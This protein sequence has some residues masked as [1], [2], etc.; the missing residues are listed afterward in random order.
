MSSLAEPQ[1]RPK[2]PI[3]KF[4]S[5]VPARFPTCKYGALCVKVL[6]NRGDLHVWVL[7]R[8]LKS[9]C[10]KGSISVTGK[11]IDKSAQ[12][13]GKTTIK[14][15]RVAGS[16]PRKRGALKKVN[17]DSELLAKLI[18]LG[19]VKRSA[20]AYKSV[21]ASSSWT[22]RTP[23]TVEF[24]DSVT[25]Q[26]AKE[27]LSALKTQIKQRGGASLITGFGLPEPRK[28]FQFSKR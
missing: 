4:R 22:L 7:N 20:R 6:R 13:A 15:I 14:S 23:F 9:E 24:D 3:Q 1:N 5:A 10:P 25:D 17:L 26:Q 12:S 11:R 18:E 8:H 28:R 2:S 16:K 27:F 21:S 19:L